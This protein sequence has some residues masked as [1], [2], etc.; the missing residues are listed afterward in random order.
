MLTQTIEHARVHHDDVEANSQRW[1]FIYQK[2]PKAVHRA[3]SG[4]CYMDLSIDTTAAYTYLVFH[5]DGPEFNLPALADFSKQTDIMGEYTRPY[6]KFEG[7]PRSLEWVK[8]LL[9]DASPWR[10]LLNQHLAERDP[11]IINDAGWVFK[12]GLNL[13]R[14]L[15]YNFAMAQRMLWENA[16][17]AG[18]WFELV[19]HGIEPAKALFIACNFMVSKPDIQGPYDVYY[20]WSFL[21]G[22]GLDCA[23]HFITGTPR[24]LST[25]EHTTPN[26]LPLWQCADYDELL[27]ETKALADRDGLTLDEVVSIVDKAT[28][29]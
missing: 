3:Y 25:I 18:M 19:K 27:S 2:G 21:E 22:G 8:F 12:G 24:S 20:P 16:P 6:T 29:A 15:F 11:E 28:G 1:G 7:T 14:R 9:S 17:A 5:G 10:A 23:K 26:V 4:G 13:P